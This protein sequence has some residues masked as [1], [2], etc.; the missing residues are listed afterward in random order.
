MESHFFS[1]MS[2]WFMYLLPTIVSWIQLRRGKTL[3]LPLGMIFFSNLL[4]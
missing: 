1:T 3:P 4:M 2:Q